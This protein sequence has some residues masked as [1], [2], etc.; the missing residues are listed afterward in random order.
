M[1][2][3]PPAPQSTPRQ[4]HVGQAEAECEADAECE[5]ELL[6]EKLMAFKSDELEPV[7]VRPSCPHHG[8]V[9]RLR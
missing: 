4:D 6:R 3:F 2:H 1:E 8:D 5:Y 9:T 7:S